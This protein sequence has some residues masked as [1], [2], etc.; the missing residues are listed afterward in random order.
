MLLIVV[1]RSRGDQLDLV[2]C[3]TGMSSYKFGFA[4]NLFCTD[5]Y[6]PIYSHQLKWQHPPDYCVFEL[7][8]M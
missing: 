3:F 8:H 1:H 5:Q 2:Q 6:V 4:L 7:K